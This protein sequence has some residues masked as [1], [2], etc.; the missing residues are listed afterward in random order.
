LSREQFAIVVEGF[1]V[2]A[3]VTAP[4]GRP[5]MITS[6]PTLFKALA[7]IPVLTGISIPAQ[8]LLAQEGRVHT[9]EADTWIVREGQA[10]HS[11]FILVQGDVEIVKHADGPKPVVLATLHAADFFGEMCVVDPVARAASVR[12]VTAVNAIEIKAGTLYHLYL[13]MPDQYS[14]VILNLARD[15]AR[16][17]RQLDEVFATRTS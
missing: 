8:T 11:F 9:F 1:P 16:R 6:T 10:G 5:L 12:A 3:A 13:K 15:M 2:Y 7:S 14:I 4:S 17:L